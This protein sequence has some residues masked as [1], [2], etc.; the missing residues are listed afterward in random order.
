MIIDVKDRQT[1]LDIAVEYA[2]SMDASYAIAEANGISVTSLLVAGQ[3][4]VIPKV[5]DMT[6]AGLFAN[7]FRIDPASEII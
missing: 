4:L 7:R 5:T 3:Q 6:T 2:G 1:V